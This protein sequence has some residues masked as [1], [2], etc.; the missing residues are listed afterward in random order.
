MT[1]LALFEPDPD[2]AVATTS[3]SGVSAPAPVASAEALES[4]RAA[5]HK[6]L[7]FGLG[8]DST[9]LALAIG[10]DPTAFGIAEDFSDFSIVTAMTGFE[11]P[12]TIADVDI[13][14]SGYWDLRNAC[15]RESSAA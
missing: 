8:V 3:S 5:P 7:N 10:N 1:S 4:F 13:G 2:D 15:R 6:S 11:F 12:D 9:A 14:K